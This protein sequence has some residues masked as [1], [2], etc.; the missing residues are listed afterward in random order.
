MV[1][2]IFR[3]FRGV[4][5]ILGMKLGPRGSFRFQTLPNM[6]AERRLQD[7]LPL[8]G[9]PWEASREWNLRG[10][11]LVAFLEPLLRLQGFSL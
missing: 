11:F 2:E 6:V 4:L 9:A 1:W 3:R 8:L 10:T 7:R 5:G